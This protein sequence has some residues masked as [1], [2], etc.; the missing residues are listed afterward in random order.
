[1]AHLAR[2]PPH[3]R[4]GQRSCM[5]AAAV[6]SRPDTLTSANVPHPVS[7]PCQKAAHRAGSA[8]LNRRRTPPAGPARS[9]NPHSASRAA[10][11]FLHVRISYASARNPST[12]RSL[13][14]TTPSL[15]TGRPFILPARRGLERRLCCGLLPLPN[16]RPAKQSCGSPMWACAPERPSGK[17]NVLNV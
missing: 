2:W 16:T 12:K 8:P 11:G 13:K 6:K 14:M 17:S 10:R 1:M 4:S 9:T 5:C 15:E 7:K 3:P